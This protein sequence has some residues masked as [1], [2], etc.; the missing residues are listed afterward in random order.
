MKKD[1]L[2]KGSSHT[3]GIGL[4]LE[5]SKR[6]NDENWLK[7]NGVILPPPRYEEDWDNINKTRWPKIVCDKLGINEY[8]YKH[9]PDLNYT[10]LPEFIIKLTLASPEV[11]EKH[12][13]HIIYEPQSTRLFY[14]DMQ[15]T[16]QEML[17][18]VM[19]SSVSEGDKKFIYDWIDNYENHVDLGLK[20]LRKAMEIHKN[21]NFIFYMFYGKEM[22][23]DVIQNYKDIE[24]KIVEFEINGDK[25]T[26]LHELLMIHKLRVCDTAYCYTNRMDEFG[27][28]KWKIHPHEDRHAGVEAQPIIADN[29]IRY[30]KQTM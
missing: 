1:I 25:S 22:E 13:S 5:L 15:F 29:I 24:D 11:L 2:F 16:P 27:N 8:D 17:N 9:V 10:T 14:D 4:D 20:L 26:N 19:D 18:I 23:L 6:Y 28:P 12:V 7:E 30:I 3:I 21:I